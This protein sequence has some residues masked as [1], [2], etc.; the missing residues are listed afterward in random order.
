MSLIETINLGQQFDRRYVLKEINLKIDK[1]EVFALIGPTGAGKT[2]LLRL[3]DLLEISSSGTVYFDGVDV[4]HSQRHRLEA[5]RRMSFVQQK[6]LVFTTSVYN[7]IACGLK[8]RHEKDQATRR[9]VESVL[10]LVDMAPYRSRNAKTLSGGETQRVAIARALVTEPEVLFLD[11]PTANLDPASAA[12][13]EEILAHIIR[14]QKTTVVM[15]TH[16][17][18]QGQRIASRIGVLM[19]GEILQVGTPNEIFCLPSTKEVAE[20]IGVENILNGIVIEKDANLATIEVNGS[21][22]QAICDYAVGD[23][24]YVIIRPEDITF[25]LAKDTS[26]ARNVFKGKI[27][28]TIPVGPLVRIEVDCGFPLLGVVTKKSAEELEF[29]I[30]KEVYASF[31]ATAIHTI[32][33]WNQ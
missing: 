11:E 9:K 8:W 21:I 22:I 25:T 2:T 23:R 30:G 3:L 32:K 14:E 31:K 1:G 16:D 27:T 26:S 15:A 10:E 24:V 7:N 13:V 5:R 28:R 19:S 18:S 17:M 12:K 4:T 33:R 29:S 6:P 20:F